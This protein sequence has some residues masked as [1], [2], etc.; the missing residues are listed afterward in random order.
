MASYAQSAQRPREAIDQGKEGLSGDYG[1]YHTRE[2]LLR[3]DGVFLDDFREVVEAGCDG[4]SQE[5]ET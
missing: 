2:D 5:E 4:E 1:V 3:D